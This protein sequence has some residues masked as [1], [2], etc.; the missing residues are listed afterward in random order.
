[1]EKEE[2]GAIL[3]II[4]DDLVKI[5]YRDGSQIRSLKGRIKGIE[6]PLLFIESR[7]N[8][9]FINVSQIIKI[10]RPKGSEQ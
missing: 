9:Y 8:D 3:Q 5:I 4:K 7:Y 10:K 6:G 2:V 1:M